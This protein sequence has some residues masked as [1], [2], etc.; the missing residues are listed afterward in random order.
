MIVREQLEP[1]QE[2]K[3]KQVAKEKEAE[4]GKKRDDPERPYYQDTIEAAGREWSKTNSLGELR[5]L[6]EYLWDNY[7]ERIPKDQYK[8][9]AGWSRIDCKTVP[10][11][12]KRRLAPVYLL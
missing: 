7:E 1:Y 9:L 11:Q 4:L 8:K 3:E 2:W 12:R 10:E 6:N 5:D